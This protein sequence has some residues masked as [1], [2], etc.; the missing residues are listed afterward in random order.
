M[1]ALCH[2]PI[3]PHSLTCTQINN[4]EWHKVDKLRAGRLLIPSDLSK[5]FRPFSSSRLSSSSNSSD[6]SLSRSLSGLYSSIQAIQLLQSFKLVW[7]VQCPS[8]SSDSSDHSGHPN[9]FIQLIQSVQLIWCNLQ[10]HN[11]CSI[12]WLP[13]AMGKLTAQSPLS[14][15]FVV[16]ADVPQPPC[17]S[18]NIFVF[19]FWICLSCL[20]GVLC[21]PMARELIRWLYNLF[22]SWLMDL[23]MILSLIPNN[24]VQNIFNGLTLEPAWWMSMCWC[25]M[26]C[27]NVW[28]CAMCDLWPM[29]STCVKL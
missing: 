10:S 29:M 21:C 9:Q 18:V 7:L 23:L 17:H 14:Y 27:D 5:S 2:C 12:L 13:V 15:C 28:W 26:V 24:L 3:N 22:I 1:C 19:G 4:M 20:S 25:A 16:L 8:S 11:T 6:P